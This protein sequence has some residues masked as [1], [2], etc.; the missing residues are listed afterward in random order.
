RAW[1]TACRACPARRM[2]APRP[3]PSTASTCRGVRLPSASIVYRPPR[4]CAGAGRARWVR[5]GRA[6]SPATPPTAG[7]GWPARIC[8]WA[9]TA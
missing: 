1:P 9:A 5:R 7:A 6:A 2:P 4:A 3:P 8:L